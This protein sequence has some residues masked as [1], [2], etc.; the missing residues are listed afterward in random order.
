MLICSFQSA[1]GPRHGLIIDGMVHRL[2]GTLFAADLL[3]GDRV[4]PVDEATLLPPVSPG[5]II[6]VG[7]NYAAHAAERGEE[8]PEEPLIFLKPPS[9]VIGPGGPIEILPEMGLVHHEA[10]LAVVIGKAGRFITGEDAFAHV[11][12]YTCAN[13]V[14]ERDYQARDGQWTRAKGFDTF[15]PL[16]PWIN[17]D[18]ETGHL[19]VRCTVNDEPRQSANTRDMVFKVP[20]LIA[21]ISRVMTLYPGD[22]ILTGT[23]SGV[24]PLTPGD[25][26]TVEV[27]G[28]GALTNPVIARDA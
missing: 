6:C 21:H 1:E 23:P 28:I 10:E 17:T 3:P 26:V 25:E 12:G 27:E 7:R 9:A 4:G 19:D 20:R 15:C 24:G 22:L 18:L 14:S 5:K 13:D 8:V 16:G 2:A 11:L